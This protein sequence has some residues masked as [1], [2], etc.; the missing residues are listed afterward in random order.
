MEKEEILEMIKESMEARGVYDKSLDPAVSM[1]ASLMSTFEQA[2]EEVNGNIT[3]EQTITDGY[4]RKV[5]NPALQ[6]MLTTSEEIRKYMRDL[7]LVVAKPAGFVS[8][9]KDSAPKQGD[10]LMS[11]MELVSHPKP[12]IYKCGKKKEAGA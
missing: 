12:R 11:M 5:V 2:S 3:V 9:E 8:Q 6:P 4:I 10:R 1:L 7:G